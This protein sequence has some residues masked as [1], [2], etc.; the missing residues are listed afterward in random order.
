[1]NRKIISSIVAITSLIVPFV[2]A[3]VEFGNPPVGQALDIPT[4]LNRVLGIVW[5]VFIGFAI[6]MFIVA[7]FFFL[8]AQGEPAEVKTAQK[9]LLWGVVGVIVGILAFSIP[10][11]VRGLLQV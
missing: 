10:F 2:A 7:G 8:K 11:I 3:G 4:L 6:I 1:M 5:P 9:A